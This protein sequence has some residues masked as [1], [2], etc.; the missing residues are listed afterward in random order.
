MT[1]ES[2]NVIHCIFQGNLVAR[3]L[4]SLIQILIQTYHTLYYASLIQQTF[5][6]VEM[7]PIRREETANW[8][9]VIYI[10]T[11]QALKNVSYIYWMPVGNGSKKI[12]MSCKCPPHGALFSGNTSF[13]VTA[14]VWILSSEQTLHTNQLKSYDR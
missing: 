6:F 2:F 3:E 4:L 14:Q 8:S 7:F 1:N 13:G 9:R 11:I 10:Y 12:K 5:V